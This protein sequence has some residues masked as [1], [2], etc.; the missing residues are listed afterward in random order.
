MPRPQKLD[1]LITGAG[2]GIGEALVR[3]FALAHHVIAADLNADAVNTLS[4]EL[5]RKD[6]RV[7]PL[8]LDVASQASIESAIAS[9]AGR[10]PHVLINNAGIQHVSPL[11]EFPPET[12]QRLIAVM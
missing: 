12:W 8:A 5:Q 6:Q 2:S 4:A 3:H 1:L 7:E 10:A 9:L 11:E